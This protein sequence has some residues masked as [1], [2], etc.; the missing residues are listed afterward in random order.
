MGHHSKANMLAVRAALDELTLADDGVDGKSIYVYGEGWNFGEVANNARFVQATQLNM[1]GTGIGTF[2]DRLRDAV[3]GG[4]PF[5]EDPRLQGFATGL[6]FD[7]NGVDQQTADTRAKLLNYQDLIRVGLTGNLRDYEFVGK[8]GTVIT[9]ADVDYNGSPAGYT[10]D[11]Q[12][13][14]TYV[15][16]HDNETLFDVLQ[17]KLPTGTTLAE[18]TRAQVV[19]LSTVALGQGVPFFHAGGELLRSKSL[20]RNSF[21]SGDWFNALDFSYE[22][23]NWGVGLPLEADN[24][25]KWEYMRPL[26][27]NP[28]LDPEPEHIQAA[29]AGFEELLEI[30]ESSPLFRLGDADL[31]QDRL[32]F[33]NTGPNQREGL[34]VMG[35]DDTSGTDL[36]PDHEGIVVLFNS[37]DEPMTFQISA[38]AR[39]LFQLH[40]IQAASADSV[41]RGATFDPRT[42]TFTVPARTTAVFVRNESTPTCTVLGTNGNDVLLGTNRAD[43]VCALGGSDVVITH[44]GNDIVFAGGG[45]DIVIVDGGNDI[46]YGEAGN[47][48]IVAGPGDDTVDGGPGFDVCTGGPGSDEITHCEI[49][50]S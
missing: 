2:N 39:A 15:E 34:I 1:G 44:A 35:L 12:E 37:N 21:N 13:A 31:V 30:R 38:Y 6:S 8:D 14:I 45:N 19:A 5:D 42:G 4:G 20:D 18:R 17:Y 33:Y 27:G 3:R 25:A 9:G 26:L 47:D 40:P 28:A 43:V 7:P 23:N 10:E 24:G 29:L 36:D 50:T 22:D 11:P 16:A 46:V 32:D 48:V 49:K 41:V